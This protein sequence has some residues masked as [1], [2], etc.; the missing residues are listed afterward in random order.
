ML[1][2]CCAQASLG[3]P[4]LPGWPSAA[5]AGAALL[6]AG[7]SLLSTTSASPSA[8]RPAPLCLSTRPLNSPSQPAEFMARLKLR[9][10]LMPE[11]VSQVGWTGREQRAGPESRAGPASTASARLPHGWALPCSSCGPLSSS[12]CGPRLC[13]ERILSPRP[14]ALVLSDRSTLGC[15]AAVIGDVQVDMEGG[16]KKAVR[17]R[18]VRHVQ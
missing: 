8:P 11:V 13:L 16:D 3:V 15:L 9:E 5:R 1:R 14:A 2:Y 7:A 17:V 4:R 18:K 6:V 10:L 12:S